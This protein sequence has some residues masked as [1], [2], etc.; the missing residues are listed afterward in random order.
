MKRIIPFVFGSV[1]AFN[2]CAQ[3]VSVTPFFPTIDDD[4]T[5]VYDAALGNGGL[6]GVNQVYMHTGLITNESSSPGDWKNVVGKWGQDD[7]KVKMNYIGNNKHTLSFNIKKFYNVGQNVTVKQMAFVFRNVDGSKEGKTSDLKDIFTNVYQ[8]NSSLLTNLASP[9]E[10]SQILSVGDSLR[11]LLYASKPSK[12]T[13][14]DNGQELSS[15]NG[16]TLIDFQL[17]SGLP[18]THEVIVN[19]SFNTENKQDTFYYTINKTVVVESL[20]A[21][22]EPGITRLNDNSVILAIYAPYKSYAYVIG[23]FNNWIANENYFMKNTPDGNIW[24]IQIDGL[25]PDKEYAFQYLIDGQLKIGDPY[26]EKVL[27]GFN[28][29]F[30]DNLTYPDLKKYPS[31]KTTGY[32]SVFKTNKTSFNWVNTEFKKPEKSNLV[33]YELLVRDFLKSHNYQTLLDSLDYLAKLGINAIELMPVNEF[34]GNESWGYNPAYQLA[35]DKYYGTPENLKSFIDACHD[36]GIAVIFDLVLNHACG[37][38]PLVQLYFNKQTGEVSPQSPYF[39]VVPKHPYNVC[40]DMNHETPATQYF[41]DRILKHW[42]NEFHFDGYRLDLSKGI[43][44]KFSSNNQ[45]MSAYDASRIKLLERIANVCW[46]ESPDH[47]VILEHFADNTEEKELASKGMLLW[48][49]INNQFLEA[50]MGYT[51]DLSQLSYKARGWSQP[52]LIGYMESHDEERMMYKNL[53]FGKVTPNYSVKN[54]KTALERAALSAGFFFP[55][56]GPKMVWMFGELG[57]D[58]SINTCLDGTINTACRLTPKPIKWDYLED[59]DRKRL[60]KI[61]AALIKLKLEQPVFKT[62]DFSTK[63]SGYQK[64]IHLNSNDMN[65]AILGNFDV[66]S[67]DVD[68]QFQHSGFWYDYF[69]GDSIFVTGVNDPINFQAGEYHLYLDKKLPLPDLDANVATHELLETKKIVIYPNPAK[70]NINILFASS[71]PGPVNLHIVDLSGRVI[72]SE[73]FVNLLSGNIE[74]KI[75]VSQLSNSDLQGLFF[76]KFKSQNNLYV[77]KLLI[78]ND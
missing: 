11:V 37:Q 65:A 32:V 34:E 36:K 50:S 57:Y 69:S 17:K 31:G 3:I 12:I 68:P 27:D 33:I 61:Y 70:N 41:V 39:N 4:V 28:D 30:I 59:A 16:S 29:G 74:I 15:A 2:L 24:W 64:T 58:Y 77:E 55:L 54:F 6:I 20:P 75:K 46:N 7:P 35:L 48:G 14:T 38:N 78:I 21:N 8:T 71:D 66:V 25:Q 42:I 22:I 67:A 26:S 52:N 5:V 49:N 62:T 76:V 13:I 72:F 45:Q 51:S 44:Q 40:Y 47:Y 18:G 56:P 1:L 43:T 63:L 19:T 9:Q 53:S 60:Y 23:D 73:D 10:K